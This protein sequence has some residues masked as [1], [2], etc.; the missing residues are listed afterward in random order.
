MA[1]RKVPD[2]LIGRVLLHWRIE[3]RI[4]HGEMAV[5]YRGRHIELD[6]TV[7]IKVMKVEWGDNE[8]LRA[9]FTE[10]AK[11]TALLEST[12]VVRVEHAGRIEDFELPYFVMEYVSGGTLTQFAEEKAEG[13]LEAEEA[14]DFLVQVA[15]GLAQ[16]ERH[17]ILHRDIK[18]D[19][20]LLDRESSE[21][22]VKIAD[23]GI[24]KS[25]EDHL[26]LTVH[27]HFVGTEFYASPEQYRGLPMDHRSDLYSL[28]TTFYALLTD[29]KK[30]HSTSREELL[31]RKTEVPYLSP[32]EQTEEPSLYAI[33]RVIAKLT[34]LEKED[35][36][37]STRELIED[38]ERIRR[39]EDPLAP[40]PVASKRHWL[41]SRGVTLLLQAGAWSSVL[42]LAL[43]SYAWSSGKLESWI[44]SQPKAALPESS[45][46]SS[47]ESVHESSGESVREATRPGSVGSI[48]A[49]R[50]AA[51]SLGYT[52]SRACLELL[53][54]MP[55]A[56]TELPERAAWAQRAL[57]F[58]DAW[59]DLRRALPELRLIASYGVQ[60]RDEVTK[61]LDDWELELDADLR[62]SLGELGGMAHRLA[63]AQSG[64]GL[65]WMSSED[66]P[67]ASV[68]VDAM[69]LQRRLASFVMAH[70]NAAW[71][72]TDRIE[73]ARTE[74]R[75]AV[76]EVL[77]E[78]GAVLASWGKSLHAPISGAAEL[79][80][81]R[82]LL[83]TLGLWAEAAGLHCVEASEVDEIHGPLEM[84]RE[85]GKRA[86]GGLL[87]LLAAQR[88]S[89]ERCRAVVGSRIEPLLARA[90]EAQDLASEQLEAL[91]AALELP[92]AELRAHLEPR[93]IE[94]MVS[95]ATERRVQELESRLG[96][97]RT[98]LREL[99][100]RKKEKPRDAWT[101]L[102][103]RARPGF[104]WQVPERTWLELQLAEVAG[105]GPR[106]FECRSAAFAGQHF[107][108]VP[109]GR[110][111]L[112][113]EAKEPALAA[114]YMDLAR[115]DAV[116]A[117]QR[118][119]E[120]PPF[121]MLE[122]ELSKA[123]VRQIFA[124]QSKRAAKLTGKRLRRSLGLDLR[125]GGAEYLSSP[126]AIFDIGDVP[127]VIG[128]ISAILAGDPQ[129]LHA[130]SAWQWL[131]A[132]RFAPAEKGEP[133]VAVAQPPRQR[134]LAQKRGLPRYKWEHGR[135]TPTAAGSPA[136][137]AA[138]AW[139][140]SPHGIQGMNSGLREWVRTKPSRQDSPLGL[141][142]YVDIE[143][144][145]SRWRM[146][147]SFSSSDAELTRSSLL[148]PSEP[149]GHSL[150]LA[151]SPGSLRLVIPL[152]ERAADV[153]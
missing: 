133:L 22:V 101:I 64:S 38:C 81:R 52:E 50:P 120:L 70:E 4:G 92:L 44:S 107:V 91:I 83:R 23:F 78:W 20:L 135:V 49:L 3:E 73:A 71:R 35:R 47:H 42:L 77:R 142:G 14:L 90:K 27:G 87:R 97:A 65:A 106:R 79:P 24:A 54:A 62:R 57:Q 131:V 2:P 12:H 69:A 56:R 61:E 58:G 115:L 147:S 96:A 122:K 16:A 102:A 126:A 100:R 144:P 118:H 80:R 117:K 140:L 25:I 8:E 55:E 39:G 45:H 128:Q 114:L 132:S 89:D 95:M 59:D 139:D 37:E 143:T 113:H 108:L 41:G 149:G 66:P 148:E 130:P 119:R 84:L 121:L 153:R 129:A 19:N 15:Q 127:A 7:A 111:D 138:F 68:L 103:D 53:E 60:L 124:G 43:L 151:Y 11:K 13:R 125:H 9:R 51:P 76:T 134:V 85:E 93:D 150:E 21:I 46:E 137:A 104:W 112:G 152:E 30:A 74:L 32:F 6:K 146:L 33:S 72:R 105:E 63:Q 94:C 31:R 86:R 123:M 141:L 88:K 98:E 109:G 99:A 26:R 10:E 1:A 136:L 40:V 75:T 36:Y 48:P 116:D 82:Q 29:I 28:G 67:Q 18:P 145:Q 17:G 34:A 5:V 110:L